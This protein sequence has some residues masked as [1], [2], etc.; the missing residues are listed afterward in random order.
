MRVELLID[1]GEIRKYLDDPQILEGF[2]DGETVKTIRRSDAL[3]L[4]VGGCCLF[5][6]VI[7]GKHASIHAAIPQ[8]IRGKKAV[9]AGKLAVNWLKRIGYTVTCQVRE[10]RPEVMAYAALCGFKRIGEKDGYI[11]YLA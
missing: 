1:E 7:G 5:P 3:Y 6:T 4:H 2:N 9:K 10:N 11:I 8:E